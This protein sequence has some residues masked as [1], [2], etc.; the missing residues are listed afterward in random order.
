MFHLT[1]DP[2]MVLTEAHVPFRKL[3]AVGQSQNSI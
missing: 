1:D 2:M 3:L